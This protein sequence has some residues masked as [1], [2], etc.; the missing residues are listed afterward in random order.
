MKQLRANTKHHIL[1][2]YTPHTSTNSFAALARRHGVTGG[3]QVVRSWYEQWD[4]TSHSLMHKPVKGRPRILCKAEVQQH[5]HAPVLRSNRAHRAINYTQ[6]L[7]RVTQ[8]TKKKMSIQTI[9]RYG[10]KDASVDAKHTKKRT[11]RESQ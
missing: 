5:M 8:K 2:E 9:R 6:L 1:L 10:K 3:A 11:A 4:H 7:P